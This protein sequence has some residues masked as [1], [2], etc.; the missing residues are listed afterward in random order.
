[1]RSQPQ[2]IEFNLS[3]PS[4][5]VWLVVK[6]GN[7]EPL[8]VEMRQERLNVWSAGASL[9]PGEYRCRYYCGDERNVI[10]YGPAR[11]NGSTDHGMD[12][13]ISIPSLRAPTPSKAISILLV[14]D[15]PDTLTVYAKLLRSDGHIVYMADGYQAALDIAEKE[16]V[17]LAICD[18]GLWDGNGCDLVKDLQK[19]Q[20]MTAIAVT[21]LVLPD[22]L[23][24]Y[25]V[26][27]FA[28]VLPKPLQY[29]QLQSVVS[30]LS[31]VHA[32]K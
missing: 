8:I 24:D 23:E 6:G 20:T 5:R 28:S 15:D 4:P 2:I 13:V 14:E 10:Y 27:G 18:I 21:G 17:D 30:D 3:C 12:A 22:E 31:P 9:I 25:R 1:M 19:L 32:S 11:T 16:R 7:H 29:S 26:A